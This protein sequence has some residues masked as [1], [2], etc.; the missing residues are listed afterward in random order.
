MH[1]TVQ[2]S[3]RTTSGRPVRNGRG[4][5]AAESVDVI[6]GMRT[7]VL[8][9]VT[10]TYFEGRTC[11]LAQFGHDRDGKGKL[12]IVFGLLC[13]AEGCPVSVEVFQ[14]N[15]GDPSTLQSQVSKIKERFALDRVVLTGDRGM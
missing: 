14:G 13:T 15:V 4:R 12:Q 11:P 7:L 8:Y 9:D 1:P 10:S 5:P 2:P 3:T 6:A